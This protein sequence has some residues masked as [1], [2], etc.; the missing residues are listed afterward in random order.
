MAIDNYNVIDISIIIPLYKG[1][2][3]CNRL[4]DLIKINCLYQ[5][6]YKECAV[7][8]I[9]VNDYPSEAVILEKE[10]RLFG[11]RYFANNKNKG[12]HASRVIGV[13]NARGRYIMMLDQDDLVKENWIYSQWVKIRETQSAICI[14]NGWKERFRILR[15]NKIFE[16]EINNKGNF[17]TNGNPIISPGQAIIKRDCIPDEWIDNIQRINGSDDFLLWILMSKKGYGF[18]LNK[19]FLYYHTP[20]RTKDSIDII[21]MIKSEREML[22]IL[23][24]I[25]VLSIKEVSDFSNYLNTLEINSRKKSKHKDFKMFD[26]MRKWIN[27]KNQGVQLADFFYKYQYNHI[28]IY[29]MG[30]IGESLY[31]EICNS[32]VYIDYAID[33]S[34]EIMDFKGELPI[35]KWEDSFSDVDVVVITLVEDY[36]E[37]IKNLKEKLSCPIITIESLILELYTINIS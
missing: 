29:G 11:I 9:F 26:I 37:V 7:E 25:G 3:Y 4:T 32:R 15:E 34:Q 35:L 24:N 20:E 14:C 8:V 30:Y 2:K 19:E 1:A 33:K 6:L 22:K 28:A 16:H 13:K 23:E 17:F 18:S 12:I 10:N 36:E 5:D 31:Y 21:H 27:I